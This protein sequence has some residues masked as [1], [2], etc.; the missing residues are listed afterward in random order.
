MDNKLKEAYKKK[1]E[2]LYMYDHIKSYGITIDYVS[3]MYGYFTVKKDDLKCE[4][5]FNNFQEELELFL[6]EM[7]TVLGVGR[8]EIEKEGLNEL[9]VISHCSC[10]NKY[11]KCAA[12][13]GIISHY[14]IRCNCGAVREFDG[15]YLQ[16]LIECDR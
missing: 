4:I 16:T 5:S 2:I 6:S 14:N 3:Y 7:E 8:I 11:L 1:I 13:Y 15:C 12:S 10:G 9:D